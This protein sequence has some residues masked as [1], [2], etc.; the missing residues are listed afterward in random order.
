MFHCFILT[1]RDKSFNFDSWEECVDVQQE[2][3]TVDLLDCRLL[4]LQVGNQEIVLL[5]IGVQMK[6]SRHPGLQKAR[7]VI[8]SKDALVNS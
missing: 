6:V 8:F 7:Q 2:M 1:F 3:K 5:A 4:D